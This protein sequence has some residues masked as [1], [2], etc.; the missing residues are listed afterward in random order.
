MNELMDAVSIQLDEA[1][2]FAVYG[3]SVKQGLETPCFLLFPVKVAQ[4]RIVGA[5]YT[6]NL[7]LDVRYFGGGDEDDVRDIEQRLF[8]ALEIVALPGGGYARGSGMH[9]RTEDG[10]LHFFVEYNVFLFKT[11]EKDIMEDLEVISKI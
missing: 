4:K 2:G 7:T 5:R 3:D 1:F 6:R 9:G 8:D 10:I 11:E